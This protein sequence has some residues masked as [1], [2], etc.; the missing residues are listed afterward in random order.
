MKIKNL[1]QDV[2]GQNTRVDSG[3]LNYDARLQVSN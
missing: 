1:V 2:D 3:V